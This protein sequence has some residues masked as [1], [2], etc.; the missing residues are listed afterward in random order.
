MLKRYSP[1]GY[2]NK[3]GNFM[4]SMPS[5]IEVNYMIRDSF[6]M[7]SHKIKNIK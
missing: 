1:R 4:K 5:L 2:H 7:V 3:S 6:T